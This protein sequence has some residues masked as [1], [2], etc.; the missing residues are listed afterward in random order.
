MFF[1][2]ISF[3]NCFL[4]KTLRHYV[5]LYKSQ[6]KARQCSRLSVIPA[7][8]YHLEH[9]F[10]DKTTFYIHQQYKNFQKKILQISTSLS[11]EKNFFSYVFSTHFIFSSFCYLQPSLLRLIIKLEILNSVYKKMGSQSQFFENFQKKK[12]LQ[13]SPSFTMEKKL[14][15]MCFPTHLTYSSFSCFLGKTENLY[16]FL[17]KS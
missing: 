14:F 12:C 3:F 17:F 8:R 7:R 6:V 11:I 9:F 10:N 16:V 15:R 13:S 2:H 1:L 4:L 5:F